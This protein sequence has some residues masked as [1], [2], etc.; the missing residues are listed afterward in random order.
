VWAG[1]L[2]PIAGDTNTLPGTDFLLLVLGSEATEKT[3]IKVKVMKAERSLS[4]KGIQALGMSLLSKMGVTR[5]RDASHRAKGP[6]ERVL[7]SQH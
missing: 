5:T 4:P 7:K 6:K 2:S 3:H 1:R